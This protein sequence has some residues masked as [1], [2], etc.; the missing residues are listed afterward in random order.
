[1]PL[2]AELQ[3]MGSLPAS[4]LHIDARMCH[5]LRQLSVCK[6]ACLEVAKGDN[7]ATL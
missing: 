1:M 6:S 2:K 7:A 5:L 4:E 3:H